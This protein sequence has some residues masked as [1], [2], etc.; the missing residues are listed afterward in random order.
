MVIRE[1]WQ[2]GGKC[3]T[4]MIREENCGTNLI[5]EKR[6]RNGLLQILY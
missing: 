2:T 4:N 3:G 5:Y 6:Q 1:L